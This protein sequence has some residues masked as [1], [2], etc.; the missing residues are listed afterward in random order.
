MGPLM[1]K[2]VH[3]SEPRIRTGLSPDARIVISAGVPLHQLPDIEVRR[4]IKGPHLCRRRR[5]GQA[6]CLRHVCK[7]IRLQS[8]AHFLRG[9]VPERD[10]VFYIGAAELQLDIGA[11]RH[12]PLPSESARQSYLTSTGAFR[13]RWVTL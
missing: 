5:V 10:E 7:A 9:K 1:P 4:R 2:C 12:S 13:C 11:R 8:P 6:P 3:N